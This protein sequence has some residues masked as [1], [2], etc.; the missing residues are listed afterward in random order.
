MKTFKTFLKEGTY[1][2]KTPW[3]VI[4]TLQNNKVIVLASS[5]KVAREQISTAHL[6]PLSVKDKSGLKVVLTKKKQDVGYPLN[7]AEISTKPKTSADKARDRQTREKEELSV[8]HNREMEKA[9]EQDF[10]KKEAEKRQKEMQKRAEQNAKKQE[11]AESH[12]E[13]ESDAEFVPEYLEDG[14]LVLVKNYKSNTPGQ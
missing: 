1:T 8:R 14:T 3:V 9:R 4:D 5:E 12:F 13:D 6:P 10:R 11:S 7:E 2:Q